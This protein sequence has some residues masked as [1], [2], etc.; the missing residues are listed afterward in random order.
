[1]SGGIL[2]RAAVLVLVFVPVAAAAGN[3]SAEDLA[4]DREALLEDRVAALES[5][6]GTEAVVSLRA[7]LGARAADPKEDGGERRAC[8][9]L[10]GTLGKDARPLLPSLLRVLAEEDAMPGMGLALDAADAL[11]RIA[12]KDGAVFDAVEAKRPKGEEL[13]SEMWAP[14]LG[15]FGERAKPALLSML[16]SESGPRRMYAVQGLAEAGEWARPHLLMAL[17]DPQH[18]VSR[19][20][21]EGLVRSRAPASEVVPVLL[22][23][24][25]SPDRRTLLSAMDALGRFGKEAAAAVPKVRA[26]DPAGDPYAAVVAAH[27]LFRLTGEVEEARVLAVGAALDGT[28]VPVQARAAA[29]LPHFGPPT[30]AALPAMA[31]AIRRTGLGVR[32]LLVESLAA[33]GS[34]EAVGPLRGVLRGERDA[35]VRLHDDRNTFEDVSGALRGLVAL[36]AKEAI[37][38]IRAVAAWKSEPDSAL[39]RRLRRQAGEALAALGAK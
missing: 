16:A 35:D 21:V 6:R 3:G 19:A 38:E 25:D 1:M 22:P 24:L 4:G 36:G 18:W 7:L 2:K 32:T 26:F 37:P 8:L 11:S 12:P 20:A 9:R 17:E 29:A 14:A 15:R 39:M 34:K 31:R 30:P 13:F 5:L 27:T 33:T 28:T 10:C 23:R